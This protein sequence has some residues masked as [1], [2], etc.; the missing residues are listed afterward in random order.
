VATVSTQ[1]KDDIVRFEYNQPLELATRF[2]EGRRVAGMNG[3]RIMYSLTD[4]RRMF[5]DPAVAGEIDQ[6]NLKPGESF[7]IVKQRAGN[8]KATWTISLS[9]ATEKARAMAE[10]PAIERDL[11]ESAAIAER[12]RAEGHDPAAALAEARK[13]AVD[14]VTAPAQWAQTLLTQ[15]QILTDVYAAAM[16]YGLEKHGGKIK[17]D[18]VRNLLVTAFIQLARK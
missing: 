16:A 18:E 12:A 17:P 15:T 6:L 14:A 10:A 9:P 5:L 13:R 2:P 1:P 4:G 11:R 8:N 3:D 7:R